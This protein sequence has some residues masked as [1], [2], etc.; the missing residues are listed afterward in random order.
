MI[1]ILAVQPELRLQKGDIQMS[2]KDAILRLHKNLVAKRDALR[3]QLVDEM[4]LTYGSHSGGG[5]VV[6]AAMD[7]SQNEL[8]SQLAALE[9]RELFQIERAIQLIRNGRYGLC[10]SCETKIPVARLN[11]LPFTT[12]CISC[13]Q[14]QERRGGV[15]EDAARNWETMFDL[16]DSAGDR[17]ITIGDIDIA[18]VG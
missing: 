7:D 17:E 13:Q 6:D 12:R 5:D 8:H 15:A 16:D 11:A 14:K 10:E 3:N 9:S 1:C 2:R 4:N 18:D